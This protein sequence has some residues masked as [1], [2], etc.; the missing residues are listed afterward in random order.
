MT[1]SAF[2]RLVTEESLRS[3]WQ[4]FWRDAAK[5]TSAGVDGVTP[6]AFQVDLQANLKRL[7]RDL[8]NG[9]RF[10]SLRGNP[11]PKPD[12]S[13]RI[14]CVPTVRDRLVQ[15]LIASHLVAQQDRLGIANAVSF[16][17]VKSSDLHKRGVTA[18]RDRAIELRRQHNWAYKS[19][20]SAFFDRI[21][22]DVL[23]AQTLAA[24]R[25]PSF[26]AI[27]SGVIGCELD[28][29][30]RF[31]DRIARANGLQ[32]GLGV[33]QGMPLSPLF[34]N[35]ILKSFDKKVIDLG[36]PMVRYADDFIIFAD[37]EE[38]CLEIDVIVRAELKKI[39]QELP[40]LGVV[41]SK[42]RIASPT[43][44]IEFLGLSLAFQSSGVYQLMISDKQFGKIKDKFG[45][46]KDVDVL[47]AQGIDIHG[48][49]KI[50]SNTID[51]Y[52]AAYSVAKNADNLRKYLDDARVDVMK[53]VLRKIFGEP[54]LRRCKG[55]YRTFIGLG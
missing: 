13:F 4:K 32:R 33:R 17:F 48:L 18:A 19:D 1:V 28:T 55:P 29:S 14:I 53:S 36:L 37:S 7:K 23:L 41:G 11:I 5:Q 26:R 42:T 12:G 27:L 47:C 21:P 35:L 51:G 22:R 45:K 39:Q 44:D 54:A 25:S 34:A 40:S 9:Y 2:R 30:D 20:I 43:E 10:S 15:R 49:T 16:G 6:S 46:L 50:L 52:L 38:R 24:L 8:E 31:T 3:T